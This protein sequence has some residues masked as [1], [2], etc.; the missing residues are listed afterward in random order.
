MPHLRVEIPMAMAEVTNLR[1]HWAPKAKRVK[2]QRVWVR[3]GLPRIGLPRCRD[4]LGRNA[5]GVLAR[6]QVTRDQVSDWRAEDAVPPRAALLQLALTPAATSDA[7]R[8]LAAPDAATTAIAHAIAVESCGREGR[9]FAGVRTYARGAA[10]LHK[11][12]GA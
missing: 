1:E 6:L 3:V 10:F 11:A 4:V 8:G 7:W 12:V 2:A 9:A 5:L